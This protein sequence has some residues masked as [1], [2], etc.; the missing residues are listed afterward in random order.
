MPHIKGPNPTY[1]NEFAIWTKDCPDKNLTSTPTIL[2]DPPSASGT[3]SGTPSPTKRKFV[4]PGGG[5]GSITKPARTHPPTEPHPYFNINQPRT[6]ENPS[7]ISED[8]SSPPSPYPITNDA[9]TPYPTFE[10]VNSESPTDPSVLSSSFPSASSLNT[11]VPSDASQAQTPAPIDSGNDSTYSPSDATPSPTAATTA[12][13]TNEFTCTGDRCPIDSQCRSRYGTCGPGF[14]YCNVYST[15]DSTCPPPVPGVTPT[16]SPTPKPTS[17]VTD[18]TE[19]NPSII[20][21]PTFPPIPRPT[22][23][24]ITEAIPFK[25]DDMSMPPGKFVESDAIDDDDDDY[26]AASEDSSSGPNPMDKFQTAEY[27]D[28]WADIARSGETCLMNRLNLLIAIATT[29]YLLTK[30]MP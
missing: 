8:N 10:G 7:P 6:T 29:I 30:E 13:A 3:S 14:I 9:N 1:C 23:T 12:K 20:S 5:K 11:P 26:A 27:L 24:T 4:K 15:W 2:S 18:G 22:L 16:R 19:T 28:L 25:L 21:K 17:D